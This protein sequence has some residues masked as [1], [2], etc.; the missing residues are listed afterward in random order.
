[1]TATSPGR[2]SRATAIVLRRFGALL[3]LVL[4][5]VLL[6]IVSEHFLTVD[7]LINVFRQSAVNALLAT[8]RSVSVTW[9]TP[10]TTPVR[11]RLRNR[12]VCLG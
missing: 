6:S 10:G 5:S 9:T 7:N 3:A 4:I 1:M 12:E 8:L 2:A 11:F